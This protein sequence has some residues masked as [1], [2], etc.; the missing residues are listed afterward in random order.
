MAEPYKL[1][2]EIRQF[3][4]DK[5]ATNLKLSCRG[6]APLIKEN[7]GINLSKSTINAIIKENNLSNKVGRPRIRQKAITK[8]VELLPASPI[9]R[10]AQEEIRP[11][12][13]IKPVGDIPES[14]SIIPEAQEEVKPAEPIKPVE[15][16]PSVQ[17][18]AIKSLREN[19][20]SYYIENGGIL[21]LIIADQK[22]GLTDFLAGKVSPYIP[23]LSKD[24]IR[25]LIRT[26][27]YDQIFQ[28]KSAPWRLLGRE[29]VCVEPG[30]Y[31]E[32]LSKVPFSQLDM[33][34]FRLG[35]E[36][37]ISDSNTLYKQCLFRLN[38][39]VQAF[40]F[41]SVYQFLDFN[42][43]YNR[44]YS[45]IAKIEVKGGLIDTQL[46]YKENFQLVHDIVWQEDFKFVVNKINSEKIFAEGEQFR[47]DENI[48]PVSMKTVSFK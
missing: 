39:L 27:I 9:I 41:P 36:H 30:V 6:I 23:D 15:G 25:M 14:P 18:I 19:G 13:P 26:K 3:I 31:Y 44:F 1:K 22:S 47:F 17:P 24:I 46:F 37:N 33:D 32:Q 11:P 12:E 21:F 43:M 10:E 7:F 5:K 4:I 29:L 40:F 34:F 42:T 38:S 20:Q 8:P 2:N 45:L 35:L 16:T 48:G 28:G